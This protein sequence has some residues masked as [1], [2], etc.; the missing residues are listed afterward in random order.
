MNYNSFGEIVIYDF[1][2]RTTISCRTI[3]AIKCRKNDRCRELPLGGTIIV[4]TGSWA[5]AE[6][7][8]RYLHSFRVCPK[9]SI[10][11]LQM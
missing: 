2:S 7:G 10:Y 11:E 6:W 3:P 8:S 9:K 1:M 5:D 4:L